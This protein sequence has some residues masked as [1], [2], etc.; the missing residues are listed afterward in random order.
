MRISGTY[1]RLIEYEVCKSVYR[2]LRIIFEFDPGSEYVLATI[3]IH[4]S[5]RVFITPWRTGE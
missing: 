3:F 4:A 5:R 1:T 2:N